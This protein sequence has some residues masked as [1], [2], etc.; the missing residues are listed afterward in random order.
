MPSCL[1]ALHTGAACSDIIQTWN[2]APLGGTT[3]EGS[4][5]DQRTRVGPER[6]DV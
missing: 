3:W 1:T 5:H 4:L 6:P 2:P